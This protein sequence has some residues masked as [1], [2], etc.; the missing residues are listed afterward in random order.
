[1]VEGWVPGTGAASSL[2]PP[3]S[4]L[5]DGLTPATM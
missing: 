3:M 1:V 5:G 4:R 2:T